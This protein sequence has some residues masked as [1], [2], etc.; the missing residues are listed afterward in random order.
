MQH[1]STPPEARRTAIAEAAA[2]PLL[3][4]ELAGGLLLTVLLVLPLSHGQGGASAMLVAAAGVYLAIAAL[5]AWQWPARWRSLGPANRVTLLRAALVSVVGAACALP[6]VLASSIALL[7][8]LSLV[9]L[10]LDGVDGWVARRTGS[11]SDFGARFDMELDAFFI[12]VL[13]LAL[14]QLD[15][16]GLWVLLIGLM[17]Y[18]FVLAM[19]PWPWLAAPLPDSFRRKAVCVWQLASLLACLLPFVSATLSQWILLLSLLALSFSF[20]R[21]VLWLYTHRAGR[22]SA[23]RPQGARS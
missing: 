13:C 17:R 1:S 14:L 7:I 18:L 4:F 12:L 16:A 20:L 10:L 5:I 21:D 9:A 22:H 11:A 3:A 8:P 15:K 6:A 19:R 2:R 23:E